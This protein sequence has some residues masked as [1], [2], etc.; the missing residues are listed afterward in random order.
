MRFI[1]G[2][3]LYFCLAQVSHAIEN[4]SINS[5]SWAYVISNDDNLWNISSRFLKKIDYYT[6]LQKINNIKYPKKMNPGTVIR[7]PMQWLKHSPATASISYQQGTSQYLRNKILSPLT[8]S[9]KLVLGDEV[10]IGENASATIIFADSSEMV[11]FKNTI[12]SFDHL[13]IY[14]KTGMVDTRVRVIQGK[15]ETSAQKNKGPGSRLDIS[16]PSAI[17]SVRGT[18]Y[19]VSNNAD[20]I[21]IVEVLEG[22][23]SVAGD[24]PEKNISV[25]GGLGTRIKQGEAPIK[26]VKLL[27]SPNII[28]IGQTYY[29]TPNIE[30]AQLDKAKSYNI[31]IAKTA[32]FKGILW[33]KIVNT[34]NTEMPTDMVDGLYHFRVSAI[35]K[36]GIE[37]IPAYSHF[38]L[39]SLLQAPLLKNTSNQ[40]AN[41]ETLPSLSWSPQNNN[42]VDSYI[43]EIATDE[44]FENTVLKENTRETNYTIPSSLPFNE[45]FWRVSSVI[46]D[47]KGPASNALTFAWSTVLKE[48]SCLIDES[49]K[50]TIISWS[51]LETNQQVIIQLATDDQFTNILDEYTFN[52]TRTKLVLPPKQ[53]F[54]LRCK[55]ALPETSIVSEWA[56]VKHISQIDNGIF[57]LFGFLLLIILI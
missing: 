19:R 29:K 40:L 35:D 45:Y 16:T 48:P 1:F 23:V 37:G 53:E 51:A 47:E 10:R 7:I 33:Q 26:P 9:T 3:I 43:I 34:N 57:S 52:H 2:C 6:D 36:L 13:S 15:V 8:L 39:N 46:N 18:K 44:N 28:S 55:I 21:S 31:Q 22:E 49:A 24:D 50:N 42:K 12:V 20:N 25:A 5:K 54:Y 4:N 38:T 27:S 14:G 11:L 30:W 56:E 41:N 32:S 17:S